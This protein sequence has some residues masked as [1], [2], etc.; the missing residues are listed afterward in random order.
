MPTRILLQNV[1]EAESLL[2]LLKKDFANDYRR[3]WS[4]EDR[5]IAVLV[6][7]RLGLIGGYTFTVMTIVDYFIEEQI[8]EVHM[9]YV[10]GNFSFLGT[11]KS[12]DF[13]KIIT[14]RI[15]TLAK[16]NLWKVEI[17]EV[18]IRNAGTLCPNCKKAYK[19]P[20]EKVREDGTV[21]CQNCGKPF[22]LHDNQ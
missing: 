9:R 2:E 14:S 5:T 16:E 8:C 4:I 21:E 7:E 20:D 3:I 18:K 22:L 11:G 12:E 13:I 10:G 1:E 15:E 19:Y 17:T 6:Y